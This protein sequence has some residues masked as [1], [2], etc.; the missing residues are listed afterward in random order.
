M[1]AINNELPTI[2]HR[3]NANQI[4][5]HHG[6][7]KRFGPLHRAADA[8]RQHFQDIGRACSL[9]HHMGRCQTLL[10]GRE[11]FHEQSSYALLHKK[12]DLLLSSDPSDPLGQ[13]LQFSGSVFHLVGLD[14]ESQ[15]QFVLRCGAD[16]VGARLQRFK[17]SA[18]ERED[19]KYFPEKLYVTNR[20]MS[21][22]VPIEP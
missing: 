14:A 18:V 3:D 7:K 8:P 10:R 2:N 11:R 22:E 5:I 13:G 16:G 9:K 15:P 21:Y 20:T 1:Q 19:T 12:I 4:A 17:S 6:S